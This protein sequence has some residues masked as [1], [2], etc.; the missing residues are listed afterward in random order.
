VIARGGAVLGPAIGGGM[1]AVGFKAA[2]LFEMAALAS[3]L[4]SL[5]I[6]LMLWRV[7]RPN[8]PVAARR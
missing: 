2:A 6:F 3:V 7:P 5:A 4:A 1:L 8:A